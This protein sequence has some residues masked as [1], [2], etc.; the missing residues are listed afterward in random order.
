[1]PGSE[2]HPVTWWSV[3]ALGVY[4]GLVPCP[5]AIVVL[6]TSISLNRLGFGM[7]L[8]VAFSVGLALV[9]V[10]IGL[11]VVHAG[12]AL[13][14]LRVRAGISEAIPLVSAAAVVVAGALMGAC[15]KAR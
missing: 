6:L 2:S 9:L 8:V 5:T 10:S 14:R 11:L 12:R 4:G 3:L 15:R 1:M 13:A 7:L